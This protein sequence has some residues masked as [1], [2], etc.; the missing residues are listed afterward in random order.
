MLTGIFGA[1]GKFPSAH[2]NVHES[3]LGQFSHV[4]FSHV[5]FLGHGGGQKS[6]VCPSK[7]RETKLLG[8]I[9]RDFCWDILELP[10]KFEEKNVS[11]QIIIFGPYS[12]N[13][14]CIFEVGAHW[15]QRGKSSKT[16]CFLGTP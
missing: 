2:K 6:S 12:K 10:E 4:L 16:L 13:I 7:P 5:L 14:I 15:G 1:H 11:V 8:G 9:S 3:V